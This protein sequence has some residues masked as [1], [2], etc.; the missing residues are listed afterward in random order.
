MKLE[1]SNYFSKCFNIRGKVL[2]G[3]NQADFNC[4][5]EFLYDFGKSKKSVT[6]YNLGQRISEYYL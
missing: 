5:A 2:E 4:F 3:L 6:N 1:F